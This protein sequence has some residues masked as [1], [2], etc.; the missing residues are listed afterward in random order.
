MLYYS[1]TGE[2]I[3]AMMKSPGE[4]RGAVFKTDEN[5]ILEKGGEEKL[6]E[7]ESELEEM[8][9]S[10]S[11]KNIK[12]ME[13]YPW[14]MRALSLLAISRVFN[15]DKKMIEEMGRVAPKKSFIV[16]FFMRHFFTVESTFK[17]AAEMWR[18]HHTIGRLEV[19]ELDNDKRK[20][21]VRLYNLNFHPIFCDYLCG[22]FAAI[23][24]I[25]EGKE[26]KCEE[27]KCFFKGE[28]FFHEFL[29]TW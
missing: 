29:L 28:S 8:G 20:A 11:Y 1:V 5:F 9:H 23:A 2:A 12:N 6:K 10:F 25:V 15:M 17:K 7:V 22:Y 27:V 21:V 16:R 24:K 14:G 19:V 3:D 18:E 26:V 4:V 13:Y